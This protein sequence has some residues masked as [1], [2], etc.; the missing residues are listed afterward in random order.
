MNKCH[1]INV[2]IQRELLQRT[3]VV[4]ASS[5]LLRL[6]PK[7]LFLF[8]GE[9]HQQLFSVICILIEFYT[10]TALSHGCK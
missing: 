7:L 2:H 1:L 9:P 3:P 4:P 8:G 10:K 5:G 6:F